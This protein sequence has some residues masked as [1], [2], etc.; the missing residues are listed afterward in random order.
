MSDK[1][2]IIYCSNIVNIL[3]KNIKRSG[4]FFVAYNI[5]L[6]L[7]KRN[8]VCV[9]L[10]CDKSRYL[11]Y[12][13]L[14]KKYFLNVKLISNIPVNSF[15]EYYLKLKNRRI[16]AKENKKIIKKIFYQL[17]LLLFSPLFKLMCL[18]D[19]L[20]IFKYCGYDC[21]LSSHLKF[22]K[23]IQKN[24]NIKKFTILHDMIPLLFPEKS[25][26]FKKERGWFREL[27]MSINSK[28]FYFANSEYTKKDFM[29]YN[30]IDS[31]K[32]KTTLLACNSSFHP[33]GS[34]EIRKSKEKYNIPLDKKYL[35]SL[36]NIDPRKNLFRILKTYIEF[37]KKHN[38]DDLYFVIG[39]AHFNSFIKQFDKELN[40]NFE[41]YKDK[42]LKIGY[43]DDEDL[44][45]LYSGAEW[46]VYTSQYEGFGLPPL[47]AMASGCPVIT[48]NNSSLP[49]VVGDAGIM[50][51]WDSD[52]QHIDAYEKYY[53]NHE[54]REQNRQKGLERAKQFSWEKCTNIIVES[55]KNEYKK[56]DKL[57]SL[58]VR[59]LCCLIPFKKYR[60]NLRKNLLQEV[61]KFQYDITPKFEIVENPK[62]SIVIPVY[63]QFKVT[64]E[65]LKS[66][67]YY[68]PRVT[69][70]IIIADDCST[71]N[72]KKIEKI[73][74]GVKS[75][76]TKGNYGFLKNVKN[77]VKYAKGEYIFLMNND[78]LVTDNWLDSLYETI[79]KDDKIGIVGS[80]TLNQDGSA[81]EFGAKLDEEAHCHFNEIQTEEIENLQ[82]QEVQYCSGCSMLFSKSDWDK[83][84]GFDEQYN[85]AY[86]E[87]TDFNFKMR[88]NLGKKIICQPKSKIYHIRNLTYS[89]SANKFSRINRILFLKKWGER[90]IEE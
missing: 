75:I 22:P 33:C 51:D 40:I 77:A 2:N 55:M 74:P 43:V 30:P 10:Y 42:I 86:Y 31:K 82:E 47:E 78:M 49:E 48:S 6:E 32:I 27:I 8:D 87:D 52:E 5:L 25:I 67:A 4:I 89:T 3:Y 23:E 20:N 54:L 68:K 59:V 70:E 50:I 90:L 29:K 19:K 60:K 26:D 17:I 56:E 35:F 57:K 66:I 65:C 18:F 38:V 11:E 63:N 14:I 12:R 39:G 88:Y 28:D 71:D 53:F 72:T 24:K 62:I 69:F 76:R 81:Q 46:F 80:L 84:D 58:I 83:L 34:E 73:V 44:A 85:T 41:N 9:T 13:K 64:Y 45:P 61:I 16:K 36:C 79:I 15:T 21:A 7:L 1:L 37:I